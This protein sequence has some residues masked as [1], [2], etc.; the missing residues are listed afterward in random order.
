[1]FLLEMKPSCVSLGM[2]H[3]PRLQAA[4]STNE[5]AAVIKLIIT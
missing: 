2:K 5:L 3:S 1:M 4:D